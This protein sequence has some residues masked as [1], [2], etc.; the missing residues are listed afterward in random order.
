MEFK[1]FIFIPVIVAFLAFTFIALDQTIS[2]FMPVA[3]KGLSWIGFQAWAMYFLAGGTIKGGGK[4][5]LGY[6]VGLIMTI[7]IMEL[8][9]IVGGMGFWAFPTAAFIIVIGA[10]SL[11]KLPPLDM[12]PAFF[13][14]SGVMVCFM[15]YIEGAS[16]ATSSFS[17]MLYCTIGLIYGLLTVILRTAYE[18][19]FGPKNIAAEEV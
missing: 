8:A 10:L 9:V 3:N 7:L 19:K 14:G 5:F 12:I 16:Y 11:E 18:K 15:S 6:S 4:T 2:G 17:I 1:K 13:I